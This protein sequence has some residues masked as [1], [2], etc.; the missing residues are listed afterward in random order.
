MKGERPARPRLK[1][2]SGAKQP[3]G[4][5]ASNVVR[6]GGLMN[7]T[8]SPWRSVY[9]RGGAEVAQVRIARPLERKRQRSRGS[10][11]SDAPTGILWPAAGLTASC[12]NRGWSNNPCEQLAGKRA[13]DA[14]SVWS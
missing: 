9:R 3:Q 1:T 6:T 8:R 5:C 2:V 4:R 13:S 12:T 11:P 14:Q 7:S 10:A